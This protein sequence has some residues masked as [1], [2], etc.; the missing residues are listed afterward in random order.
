MNYFINGQYENNLDFNQAFDLVKQSINNTIKGAILDHN[1]VINALSNLGDRLYNEE[2]LLLEQLIKYG[3]DKKNAIETKK[4]AKGVLSKDALVTKFRRELS[5]PCGDINRIDALES[6]YEGYQPLG[7]LCHVTSGNAPLLPFFSAVEGLLTGNINVIKPASGYESI[8]E[9]LC[10]QVCK[11]E[12]KLIPYLFVLPL[13]SKKEADMRRFLALGDC[14]AVWGS[15]NATEGVRKLMT[16]GTKLVEWGNR[17]SFVY[18]TKEGVSQDSLKDI[19]T[20]V[21]I[22]NQLACSAPQIVYY[23]TDSKEDLLDFSSKLYDAMIKYSHDFP[24]PIIQSDSQAELTSVTLLEKMKEIEG[25][26]KVFIG[27]D[28]RI[29]TRFDTQFEASPLYRTIIVKAI[30]RE[31]IVQTLRPYRASLQTCSLIC[32]LKQIVEISALLFA[33]GVNRVV[34]SGQMATGYPGE[35]HDGVS[36]LMQYVKKVQIRN[37]AFPHGMM[38]LAEL[39]PQGEPPFKSGTKIL[40]KQDFAAIND[41]DEK[42]CIVLKSGGSSG[43]SVYARHKYIDAD[44]TY[45]TAGQAIFAAGL[46]PEKDIIMNLF[47]SGELYGSFISIYEAIKYLGVTQLPMGSCSD[48]NKVMEEIITNKVNVLCGISSYLVRFLTEKEEE[49]KAYGKIEKIFYSGEHFDDK[50]ADAFKKKLGIKIIKSLTY[51]C[52]EMGTIGYAC[53]ECEGSV[54]HLNTAT[55][56]MEILK[57]D[58]DEPVEGEEVGRIVISSNDEDLQIYRY[59]IGDLGRWIKEPCKCGRLTPRFELL[60]RFGDIFN[61]GPVYMNANKIKKILADKLDY[62]GPVQIILKYEEKSIMLVYVNKEVDKDKVYD[63]LFFGCYDAFS[64]MVEQ[65]LGE[66]IIENKE[67]SEFITSEHGNKIKSVVDMGIKGK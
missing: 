53:S 27:P 9:E 55:K 13:S 54:H 2:E 63:A 7:V 20:D 17:I 26:S 66:L 18:I 24:L 8:V 51:G 43:H 23:E 4:G 25:D 21:C 36:S 14:I 47:Y 12:P 19:T 57:L 31:G 34:D 11:I 39:K 30:K 6:A 65:K 49:L 58:K 29:F 15:N 33:S 28:F 5:S 3:M 59:E 62:H 42:G 22:N 67:L 52:N 35:A 56:Y 44:N 48:Y 61:F 16:P 32:D 40:P 1:V 64:L 10:Y 50:Q 38:S 46:E 60:G 37:R 45:K 41:V